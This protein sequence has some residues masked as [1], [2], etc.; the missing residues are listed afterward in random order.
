MN[1]NSPLTIEVVEPSEDA[2]LQVIGLG[3][4]MWDESP[5]YRAMPRDIDKMIEF[6]YTMMADPN[7][8]FQ[9]AK[10]GDTC[11][12]FMFG[13]IAPYGFVDQTF[14]FD[15]LLYVRPDM[16]GSTAARQLVAAFE[17]W[18][19]DK[20]ASRIILAVTTG[21]HPEQTEKFYNKCG[22]TTVGKLTMKEV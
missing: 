22:Y 15:R 1:A 20:G 18:A 10:V 21:V 5:V 14:A 6:A 7:S 9:V 3:K 4:D 19:T 13:S 11:H 8:F 12:G 16:R 17:Q 2:L